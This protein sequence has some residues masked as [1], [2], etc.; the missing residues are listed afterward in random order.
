MDALTHS[1]SPPLIVDA[2][3]FPALVKV[4]PVIRPR[5]LEHSAS[6][7]KDF[8]DFQS[9]LKADNSHQRSRTVNTGGIIC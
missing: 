6:G 4:E 9:D 8:L 1:E 7:I 3:N 2:W 5:D